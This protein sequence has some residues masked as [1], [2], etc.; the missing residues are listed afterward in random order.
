[1]SGQALERVAR[2]GGE[3]RH[4]VGEDGLARGSP[5]SSMARAADEQRPGFESSPPEMA[6]DDRLRAGRAQARHQPGDLDAVD[7]PRSAH[8]VWR[9]QMVTVGNFGMA[10]FRFKT[11]L[12]L[13]Q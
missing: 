4:V 13:R 8:R 12:E 11:P 10:R 7:H 3:A 5:S 2:R 1:M 6:E 9:G